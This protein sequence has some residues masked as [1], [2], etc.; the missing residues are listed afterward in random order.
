M[1]RTSA[2]SLLVHISNQGQW[3]LGVLGTGSRQDLKRW[4]LEGSRHL[5][6]FQFRNENP[7][8]A[9]KKGCCSVECINNQFHREYLG[10]PSIKK[11]A[12]FFNIVQTDPILLL[13]MLVHLISMQHLRS[14]FYPQFLT[15]FIASRRKWSFFGEAANRRRN[16]MVKNEMQAA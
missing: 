16:S 11:S 4:E 6:K 13:E 9:F 3:N 10:K 7:L 15:T 1:D 2:K 12:V 8:K 5:L 14:S